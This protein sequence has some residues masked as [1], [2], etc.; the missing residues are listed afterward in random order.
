LALVK[1]LEDAATS[2]ETIAL[3]S[4]GDESFLNTMQQV[5]GYAGARA[6]VAI[7]ALAAHKAK[8]QK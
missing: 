2:L 3:R 7:Q 8:E 4:Y 1:A 5:R 6:G